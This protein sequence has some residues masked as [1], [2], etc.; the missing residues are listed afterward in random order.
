MGWHHV[1]KQW[2]AWKRKTI[3]IKRDM[4][5]A[6]HALSAIFISHKNVTGTQD[7]LGTLLTMPETQKGKDVG[8]HP[9]WFQKL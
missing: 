8:N 3:P 2:S 1:S 7:L 9:A 6:S 4:L 5:S